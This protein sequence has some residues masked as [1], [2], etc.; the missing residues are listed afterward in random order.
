MVVLL[1]T[2]GYYTFYSGT[3]DNVTILPSTW[4]YHSLSFFRQGQA[5]FYHGG[6]PFLHHP[7]VPFLPPPPPR[8]VIVEEQ[9]PPEPEPV[10][11]VEVQAFLD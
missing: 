5:P 7:V 6:A 3:R 4:N 8:I 1:S 2:T 9:A 11:H 10:S